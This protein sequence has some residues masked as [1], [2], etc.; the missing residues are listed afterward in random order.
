VLS[1]VED[2]V[3]DSFAIDSREAR[4]VDVPIIELDYSK[5]EALT[6]WAPTTE[7]RDGVAASWAWL[8]KRGGGA[9]A[10]VEPP[11]GGLRLR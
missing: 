11:G 3:D 5:I 6:G 4:E 7:L 10:I 2:V 9:E 1:V 8:L